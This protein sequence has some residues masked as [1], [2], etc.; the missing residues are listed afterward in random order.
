MRLLPARRSWPKTVTGLPS[1]AG[2]T[3]AVVLIRGCTMFV[4]HVGDSG[5]M[6]GRHDLYYDRVR[7]VPLTHDH[8]PELPSERE[9]I[10]SL[11]GKVMNKSGVNRVV[12]HRPKLSHTGPIRRSTQI[13]CIPF[14]AVARSL[15][16]L[17][18]YD[19]G[20]GKYMVSP[21]PDI[22]VHTVD[23]RCDRFIVLASDGLWNMMS[24][25][26]VCN[27]VQECEARKHEEVGGHVSHKLVHK[28]LSRWRARML[29]A[30]NTTAITIFIDSPGGPKPDDKIIIPS[31]KPWKCL[32]EHPEPSTSTPQQLQ[33]EQAKRKKFRPR[34]LTPTK[35]RQNSLCEPAANKGP[36]LNSDLPHGPSTSAPPQQRDS[37]KRQ[38]KSEKDRPRSLTPTL[39]RQNAVCEPTSNKGHML[40]SD[41]PRDDTANQ[42]QGSDTSANTNHIPDNKPSSEARTNQDNDKIG[43]KKP[44]PTAKEDSPSKDNVE[45]DIT[46]AACSRPGGPLNRKRAHAEGSLAVGETGSPAK[47]L[48]GGMV[49]ETK[50]GRSLRSRDFSFHGRPVKGRQAKNSPLKGTK[51]TPLKSSQRKL[52][53]RK[54]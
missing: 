46:K 19:Y 53:P 6:M 2:T 32:A 10:E 41:P 45:N 18:S 23:P 40:N 12:W 13:D 16:D 9:R 29:R 5:I 25:Q 8:K 4:A 36:K 52:T 49:G 28:A 26:D 31:K 17:W 54:T 39:L 30:D 43:D 33:K 47:K 7:A 50:M 35:Y 21:E 48:K 1:T 37:E 44:D 51:K 27:Y 42:Q 38:A 15:G 14:L 3:A 20:S 34:S 24:M 22:S 11:G